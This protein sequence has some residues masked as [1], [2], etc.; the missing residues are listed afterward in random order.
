M[1]SPLKS[2][3]SNFN[4]NTNP[5]VSEE[6]ASVNAN[7]AGEAHQQQPIVAV[8]RSIAPVNVPTT[9]PMMANDNQSSSTGDHSNHFSSGSQ[10]SQQTFSSDQ[11][12]G[13]HHQAHH[14]HPGTSNS[15]PHRQH[16]AVSRSH[17]TDGTSTTATPPSANH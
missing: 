9:Q 7:T 12:P 4:S 10:N 8:R 17:G 13:A 3:K 15:V 16:H 11:P 14:H 2:S 5:A 6:N 1:A